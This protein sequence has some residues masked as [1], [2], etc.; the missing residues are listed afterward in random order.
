MS[1]APQKHSI[2]IIGGSFAGLTAAANLLRDIIPALPTTTTYKVT[3]INP[4]EDFYWKIGAPRTIANPDALPLS[5]TLLPIK[6]HF[7]KYTDEQFELIVAYAKAIDP[8]SKTV[9]LSTGQ[10]V[11][12]DSLV[13]A[14]GTGFATNLWSTT[15]GTD[16]L[17]AELADI[18]AQLQTAE[19]IVIAGGGAAGVETAGELGERKITLYSGSTQLLNGLG[20]KRVGADAEARL[21]KFG[22]DVVNNNIQVTAHHREE[23]SGKTVLTLSDGSS[24]TADVYIAATGDKPNTSF[25][26]ADW[27]TDRG[28]VKTDP[29]TLRLNVPG[30][31]NVYVYGSVGS[32][33]NGSIVDVIMAKKPF[34]ETLRNDLSGGEPGPRTKNVYKKITSD[35]QFVPIGSQQGVGVAFG[36]KVPSFV[37]K[38]FKSKDFMI[39]NAVK[40]LE[41]TA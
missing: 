2:V 4:S 9:S 3:V 6:P 18:H 41:G 36:W 25:V 27:L 40:Y 24:V 21:K 14:S 22:V 28:Q 32:Y 8:A 12:Y 17:K 13:I 35:V 10:S 30:V 31:T 16:A 29:Q 39:G 19:T 38:S 1:T 7:S 11:A 23:G 37:V 15:G 5:K 26:P 34:L 33:S 20:N